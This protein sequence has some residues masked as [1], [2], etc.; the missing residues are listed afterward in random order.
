MQK[1]NI[2]KIQ[3]PFMINPQQT[4]YRRNISQHRPSMY[5]KPYILLNGEKLKAF[6]LSGRRQGCSLSLFNIIL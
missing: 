5:D 3:K 4:G 1:K 6:P 2:D